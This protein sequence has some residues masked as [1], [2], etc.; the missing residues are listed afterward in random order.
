M[1]KITWLLRHCVD[2]AR[3]FILLCGLILSLKVICFEFEKKNNTF[4]F[5]RLISDYE[6]NDLPVPTQ[7]KPAAALMSDMREI[8]KADRVFK[9]VYPENRKYDMYEKD[10][11]VV[12]VYFES[13]TI[14]EFQKL[15][16]MTE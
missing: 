11:A 7:T 15:R 3:L 5:E 9:K 16:T 10:I 1:I 12:H 6:L 13:P 8:L 14:V 2:S 4:C